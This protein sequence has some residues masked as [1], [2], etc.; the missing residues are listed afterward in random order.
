M[1][2]KAAIGEMVEDAGI[3]SVLED[4]SRVAREQQRANLAGKLLALSLDLP[5]ETLAPNPTETKL[6]LLVVW[7]DVE[8]ELEGP[9]NTEDDRYARARQIRE[10]SDEHGVYPLDAEGKVEVS[11]YSGSSFQ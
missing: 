9:F 10:E 3:I 4:L 8:P 2:Q 11:A 6:Y 1:D 7:H 5:G